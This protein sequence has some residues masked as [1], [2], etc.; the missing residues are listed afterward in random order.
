MGWLYQRFAEINVENRGNGH[1]WRM[2]GNLIADISQREASSLN[3]TR[4]IKAILYAD[5]G[6]KCVAGFGYHLIFSFTDNLRWE[7][8]YQILHVIFFG[9]K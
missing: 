1:T 8:D 4:Q 2:L 9:S 6:A 3:L 7:K 5:R